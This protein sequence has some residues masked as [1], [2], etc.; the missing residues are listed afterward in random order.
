MLFRSLSRKF[1]IPFE[2]YT[3]EALLAVPG[4]FSASAFVKSTVG[5]DCVC[6]RAALCAGA[7]R[8][9]I[10]KTSGEGMTFALA[11]FEEEIRFA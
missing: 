3:A 1:A 10:R 9:I 11:E 8:L 7:G 6:E 2:T 4:E 5:V